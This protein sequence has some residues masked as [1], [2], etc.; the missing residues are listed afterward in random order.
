M[1]R[2]P[3]FERLATLVRNWGRWGPD[4][5]L[6]TLNF[7]TADVRIAATSLV[8]RGAVFSLSLPLQADGPQSSS[9]GRTNPQHFMVASGVDPV[10]PFDLGG[11]ARYTDDY[12]FMPL[13]AATQWDALAHIFYD[14]LLYNGFPSASVDSYGTHRN[15]IEKLRGVLVTRG[16][17]FDIPRL[18]G[19]PWLPEDD[20]VTIDDLVAAERMA[21][22]LVREGDVVLIR[23]G[24]GA[25]RAATGT[26]D[27][28]R[29]ER[30]AGVDYRTA[31]WFHE[32][33]VA[34]VASDNREVESPW[35]I[36]GIRVPF[37]MLALRDMG[38]PLGEFWDLEV[39]AEDC[40]RDG[41]YEF[42]L[43]APPLPIAGAVG[44]PV[45]PLA[46]K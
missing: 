30:M 25:I 3:D 12:I 2:S 29:T 26:W 16:V 42:M 37:H 4:D 43:V 20:V 45:N 33:G 17:L 19:L 39:L 40:V 15:W 5:E 21:G 8:Q 13:Q 9:A 10:Q 6:G 27:G 24:L 32:H 7:I 14:D 11:G 35:G 22:V 23:V 18:R 46:V 31:E 28:F 1:S 41:V 34:A 36:P 44:S 38:M